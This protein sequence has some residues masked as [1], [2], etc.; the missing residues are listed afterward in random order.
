MG[1]AVLRAVNLSWPGL[2]G[3]LRNRAPVAKPLG[4]WMTATRPPEILKE[5]LRCLL[6]YL[7]LIKFT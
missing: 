1:R 6:G 3:P 5:N 4:N 2:G 7:D